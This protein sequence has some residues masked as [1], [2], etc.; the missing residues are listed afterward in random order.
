MKAPA[1]T[2]ITADTKTM[3]GAGRKQP[4]ST[5][6]PKAKTENPT[7]LRLQNIKN[8]AFRLQFMQKGVI[9]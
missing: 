9:C 2:I 1:P 3:A 5:P 6:A 7:A 4:R 8:H